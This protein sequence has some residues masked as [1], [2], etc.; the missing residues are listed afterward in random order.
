MQ[1]MK[2][3]SIQLGSMQWGIILLTVVLWV[4]MGRPYTTLGYITKIIEVVFIVLL[5]FESR[6]GSA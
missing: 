6:K 4:F 3:K 1:K 2:Q 5:W